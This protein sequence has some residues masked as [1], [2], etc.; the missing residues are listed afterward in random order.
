M[1]KKKHTRSLAAIGARLGIFIFS[2]WFLCMSI[3]TWGT[4]QYVFSDLATGGIDYAEYALMSGRLD[5]WFSLDDEYAQSRHNVPGALEY[6]MNMAIACAKR[7]LISP[8][9]DGYPSM[10]KTFSVFNDQYID[11]DTAIVFLDKEG[12]ILRESSDFAY[13][14]Y[15]PQN[16]WEAGV[17]ET[18]ACGWIDLN[19]E[20]D[21]RYSIFRTAF[22]G[23]HDLYDLNIIRITGYMDGSRIEPL[24]MAFSTL[25]A[26]YNALDAASPGWNTES[27]PGSSEMIVS[28]DGKSATVS[29]TGGKS[30]TPPYSVSELDAIGL[31]EW[32]ER[33]D[34]TAQA[35]PTKELVTIY[36]SRPEMTLYE[37][38]G[39]VRYQTENYDNLL[40]LLKTMGY[41]KDKGRNTFY[42]GAS[43]F[44]L[45][46]MVV[47]S[48]AGIYDLRD[49]VP[50]GSEPFPDAEYTVMTAMQASPLKIA[51]SFLRNMYL[52]TFSV[53]LLGFLYINSRVRKH[54]IIPLQMMNEGI[55]SNWTHISALNEKAPKW[56]EPYEL[57][58]HYRQTQDALQNNKNEITR[59]NTALEYAKTA[60]Q[61]RRQMTSN[62]AH[63]LKTP[64]AV[65]HS[66][67]EGLKK[68][69][70]EDKRDKY[71]DVI[72]SEAERTDSMVLEMLDL[73]RLEAGKV[74]LSRDD[75]SLIALT[76]SIF[77]KLEMAA[78]AKDLQ[79]DF[80]FPDDFTIT[81]DESRIAQ[82]VENFA[83]N[84]I[85]YAPTG[86]HISVTIQTDHSSTSF[87][88]ENDSEPL[89]SEAL[90]KVWDTFYRTDEARSGGGTGLGLAIAKSIV[91]LHGGKCSVRNTKSGVEF[92]FTIYR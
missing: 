48:S 37:P 18:S 63:E 72:L 57:W 62:I 70:A 83:T 79:I 14:S 16:Q 92:G 77:E 33:F 4:A 20:A 25:G 55:A 76:R 86:G 32:D 65:I 69:I 22:A 34:Y 68:H 85:K 38:D 31:L 87:H 53:A 5:D 56:K 74:K 91:D 13:F 35:D 81:A 29:V 88:I 1:K 42:S 47:F 9:F 11:C 89:S 30:A 54:L 27:E 6:N 71:I 12:N 90:S 39:P 10:E 78:Q 19:N 46:N 64:L 84:A 51:M 59:L 82:V 43:Q 58:E 23:T 50:D 60:E 24:A 2:L 67:A 61:N 21:P 80:N 40:A 41:Y 44:D 28:E 75:F 17:D 3:L 15:I 66:Y 36:A 73:S 45:W 26:Y 49:Y 52:I 7:G 8:R